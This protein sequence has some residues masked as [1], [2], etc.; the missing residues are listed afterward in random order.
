MADGETGRHGYARLPAA[1]VKGR[2]GASVT[3]RTQPWAGLSVMDLTRRWH[4]VTTDTPVQ[5]STIGP[6][7]TDVTRR[8]PPVITDTPVQVSTI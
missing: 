1:S 8:P 3:V 5:V 7:V 2:D 4:H 6:S